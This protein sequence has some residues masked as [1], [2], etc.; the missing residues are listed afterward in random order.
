MNDD[1][2]IHT[3][4]NISNTGSN[5]VYMVHNSLYHNFKGRVEKEMNNIFIFE[6][7]TST[8]KDIF[9][10]VLIVVILIKEWD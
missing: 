5:V 3:A 2:Y 10:I 6:S 8:I 1:S 9:I 7:L 4:Y